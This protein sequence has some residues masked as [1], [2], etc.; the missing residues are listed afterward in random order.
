MNGNKNFLFKQTKPI[1]IEVRQKN[2]KLTFQKEKAQPVEIPN[3]Q[4]GDNVAFL[5][6]KNSSFENYNLSK[7][8]QNNKDFFL[9]I[10]KKVEKVN[11]IEI[12]STSDKIESIKFYFHDKTTLVYEFKNTVTG[13]PPD[14]K[15]F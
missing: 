3:S 14:E 10:P 2:G 5:F 9:V 13:T 1:L 11:K 12:I 7:T 6:D 4:S 15:L 8:I